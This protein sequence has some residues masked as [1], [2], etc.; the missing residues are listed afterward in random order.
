M[1]K[2]ATYLI[3]LLIILSYDSNLF[4]QNFPEMVS[5]KGGAFQMGTATGEKDE[6]PVHTVVLSDYYIAKHET[7]VGLYKQFCKETNRTMPPLPTKE[8]YEEYDQVGKWVWKDDNP[9]VN[10]SWNDAMAFCKWLSTKTNE[11]YSLPT[12]A[13]WE[14]AARGGQSSKNHKFSGSANLAE[15][16]W[17][18]ETTHEKGTRPVGK[19][20]ANELGVCDM[21]GNAW[22]WCL[23]YYEPYTNKT[24]KDP[25]GPSKGKFRVVRGGGWY[26]AED[27]CR[28]F[29]R[30]GPYPY[31]SNFNYGFRVVKN[32]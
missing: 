7:T 20:K 3:C 1:K 25:Q 19:L 8:W 16:G 12:E 24:L 29:T 13:Q 21:S 4:G 15:V 6:K 10:I 2:N 30:D 9:I 22:E 11:K 27:M 23:D 5:V 17:Y 32:P 14:Y 26:Y 18:D 28:V 31:Y